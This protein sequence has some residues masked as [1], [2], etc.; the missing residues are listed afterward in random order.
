MPSLKANRRPR[1]RPKQASE[2][3]RI[4]R[5]YR[6]LA[7]AIGDA[8][9]FRL[10]LATYNHPGRRDE[11]IER[12]VI[13]GERQK[14]RVTILDVSGSNREASLVQLL[15]EH[16][17][18]T[19]IPESEWRQA[20]ML[21]GLEQ[22]LSYGAAA[23]RLAVLETAN[24]Q[25]DAFPRL[26]PVP[27]VIWLS[28]LA[29]A[30]FPKAA[31]DL[32]HWRG[33]T[34]DFSGHKHTRLDFLR[35]LADISSERIR[36]LPA[37]QQRHRAAVLEELLRELDQ[38]GIVQTKRAL[39]ERAGIMIDL[40]LIYLQLSRR[41]DAIRCF[42]QI[43]ALADRVGDRGVAADAHRLLSQVYLHSE[44]RDQSIDECL[45]SLELARQVR[46]S[47][48]EAK[49]LTQL[50]RVYRHF[51]E[52]LKAIAHSEQAL[53]IARESKDRKM[54]GEVLESLGLAHIDI[55]D[56]RRAIESA[57]RALEIACEAND[58]RGESKALASLGLAY[59]HSGELRQAIG[60]F[61]KCLS[62]ARQVDAR[63]DEVE[64]LLMLGDAYVR[65]GEL[66]RAAEY[67]DRSLEIARKAGDRVLESKCLLARAQVLIG[68]GELDQ[69][70][71]LLCRAAAILKELGLDKVTEDIEE[72]IAEM[73]SELKSS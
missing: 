69:G 55:D 31:P 35:D 13:D 50:S 14:R 4:Q 51:G 68:A 29:T 19:K 41:T 71:H 15:R 21:V 32:W 27:V 9:A 10:Y 28:P 43:T 60:Y 45:K 46:N 58:R 72:V 61:E 26:A 49:A 37:Q 36:W 34:F 12:L 23:D 39:V 73:E 57:E 70:Y 62:I 56:P 5:E 25:R 38:S 54:E 42:E 44:D 59:A 67:Y 2:T 20:V 53:E 66:W 22:L 63:E 33:A 8:D 3:E 24:L 16:L 1:A 64:A 7:L 48:K 52:P 18:S 65:S 40:G 47:R 6:R 30:E 17:A 11:L